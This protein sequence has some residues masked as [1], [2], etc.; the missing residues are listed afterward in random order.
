MTN[1]VK[2]IRED[3]F[4]DSTCFDGDM[5]DTLHV[6]KSLQSLVNML[7]FGSNITEQV[8][9][10]YNSSPVTSIAHLA[11]FNA[12][13]SYKSNNNVNNKQ[14]CSHYRETSLPIYLALKLC[15]NAA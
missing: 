8:A 6:P 3:I 2:R 1:L 7:L 12:L 15:Q 11:V 13:K 14:C 9:S 4:S 10:E 5:H